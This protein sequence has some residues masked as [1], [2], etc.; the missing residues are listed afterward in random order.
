MNEIRSVRRPPPPAVLLPRAPFAPEKRSHRSISGLEIGG[1]HLPFA[2]MECGAR[3]GAMPG[4][5]K[6]CRAHAAR[7]EETG[8]NGRYPRARA[9]FAQS[10]QAVAPAR[11]QLDFTQ[12]ALNERRTLPR[13]R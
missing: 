2:S 10:R 6:E 12:A 11:D 9:N 4:D 13:R 7:C 3:V 5:P 8:Q 1:N